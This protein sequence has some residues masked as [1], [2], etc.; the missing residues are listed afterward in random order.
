MREERP[1]LAAQGGLP[2]LAEASLA[3]RSLCLWGLL[4]LDSASRAVGK[5]SGAFSD[6]YHTTLNRTMNTTGDLLHVSRLLRRNTHF[7]HTSNLRQFH[8]PYF[9]GEETKA[10][11][12]QVGSQREEASSGFKPRSHELQKQP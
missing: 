3:I 12:G 8:L 5:A 11:R 6:P 9:I 4:F 2:G 7:I 10:Q 1:S